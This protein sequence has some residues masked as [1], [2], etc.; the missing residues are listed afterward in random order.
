M[1]NTIITIS[2]LL[3]ISSFSQKTY[4][5]IYQDDLKESVIMYPPGTEFE[6][7]NE[8]NYIILKYSETPRVF[9]MD[10]KYTLIVKPD[11]KDEP[12]VFE[13]DNAGQ[14]E[15]SETIRYGQSDSNKYESSSGYNGVTA[16]KI[17]TD[18]KTTDGSKNLEF[19]LSNGIIFRYIDGIYNAILNGDYL[20][21]KGKYMIA[22]DLGTLKLSFNPKTGTVWW[23]FEN[24]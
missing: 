15:L 21:I 1:K 7:R 22:S 12:D 9:E 13:F 4:L 10:G 2:L 19:K 17:L 3:S 20:D 11:Y 8:H 23:V 18:S 16:E 14:I 5:A 24:N 6:L